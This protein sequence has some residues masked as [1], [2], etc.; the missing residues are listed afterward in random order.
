M[1][2]IV[3]KYFK[4][5]VAKYCV[6]KPQRLKYRTLYEG[7]TRLINALLKLGMIIQRSYT[8]DENRNERTQS[9]MPR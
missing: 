3:T 1:R 2:F 4:N 7:S 5:L 8:G 9:G 6:R